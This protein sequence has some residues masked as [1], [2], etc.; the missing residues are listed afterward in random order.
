MELTDDQLHGDFSKFADLD[1]RV[2]VASDGS[3]WNVGFA[4]NGEV[5]ELRID[6]NG[7]RVLEKREGQTFKHSSFL[8]LMASAGFGNLRRLA[9]AQIALLN[10]EA[11]YIQDFEKHLPIVGELETPEERAS[12]FTFLERIEHWLTEDAATPNDV[13]ALVIDGPAGIGKTHLIRRLS[14]E[15]ASKF[16][17]GSAPPLLHIQSRGRKLTTLN[18]VLAGTLNTLRIGLT[19][20]QVPLLARYGL[21]HVAIDGFDEL[22]DPYGYENAWGLVNDFCKSIQGKGAIVLSGRDTFIDVKAVRRALQLLNEGNTSAAHLRPLTAGEA[23]HWLLDNEWNENRINKIKFAGLFEEG[24]YA[25]RPFF[26][27]EIARFANDDQEFDDFIEFPLQ[28]LIERILEREVKL[29]EPF[30]Q[31]VDFFQ[32]YQMI[33]MFFEETARTMGDAESDRLDVA[34]LQLICEMIFSEVVPEEVLAVLR[35]RVQAFALLEQDLTPD[36]RRFSHSEIQDY[37]QGMNYIRLISGRETTKSMSRNIFGSDFLD[38]FY[39]ISSRMPIKE[40]REIVSGARDIIFSSSSVS[41][42]AKNLTALLMASSE[43]FKELE[44][45]QYF[46]GF[47]LDEVCLRGEVEAMRLMHGTISLLDVRG[48]DFS[49]VEIAD[50][51]ITTLLADDATRVPVS[52]PDPHNLQIVR[53]GRV[54]SIYDPRDRAAWFKDHRPVQNINSNDSEA[55]RLLLRIARVI[56]RQKWIRDIEDDLAGRLLKEPAWE[57]V[58]EVL[59]RHEMLSIRQGVDTSGPRSDFYRVAQAEEFLRPMPTGIAA[60]I[61]AELE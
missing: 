24:S 8:G 41:Q 16:G 6:K 31:N 52:M 5:V 17:P 18:D 3:D 19:F 32:I 39:E 44:E 15:R 27:S 29:I 43:R 57:R 56:N 49:G 48:C 61:K 42:E 30:L 11:P 51:V 4:Q 33:F 25:L 58:R 54:H 38:T 26:I 47:S 14:F 13:R 35:H 23:S 7:G 10:R 12:E 34:S 46:S 40:Y 2:F 53:D 22:A 60:Q 21:L 37:F 45:P 1:S 9:A 28:T 36:D 50:L 59:E 55:W 20:D